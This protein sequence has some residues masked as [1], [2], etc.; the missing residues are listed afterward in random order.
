VVFSPAGGTLLT[1]N[2]DYTWILW[3]MADPVRPTRLATFNDAALYSPDGHSLASRN[4][5]WSL[6]DPTRPTRTARFTGGEPVAFSADGTMLATHG[7]S[8]TTTLWN[9]TNPSRLTRL[10]TLAADGDGFFSPDGHTFYTR[11]DTTTTLWDVT[12]PTRPARLAT[13]AGAGRGPLS[14]D[15]DTLVADTD[16]AIVLWNLTD[17]SHPKRIGVLAGA[18]DPSDPGGVSGRAVFSPD[19]RSL[20][21]GNRDGT[22]VLWNPASAVRT[23]VLP[24]PP[25]GGN[26]IQI[27]ASDTLTTMAF[28]PDGHTLSVITGNTTVSLW[29]LSHPAQP[30]RTETLTRQTHGAGRVSFSPDTSTLA[31]AATDGSNT[32]TLWTLR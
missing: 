6:A 1:S 22:V 23:G 12:D 15:G 4:A 25:G 5:L 16:G 29:D 32:V 21:T 24:A 20:A 28:T 26:N 10:G 27:G 14:P 13:L 3:N 11:D 9:V 30:V 8:T 7:R 18:A 17:R 2:A 19:S 31:G